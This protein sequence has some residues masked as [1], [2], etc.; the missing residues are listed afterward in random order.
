M[1]TRPRIS[2]VVLAGGRSRRFG[3]DKLSEVVDGRP[4]LAHAVV[5]V[6]AVADEVIVVAGVGELAVSLEGARVVHDP[7]PFEGPLAGLAVGLRACESPL[8]IVIGGDMPSLQSAVGQALLDRLLSGPVDAAVL[9]QEGGRRP[10]PLAVRREPALA[11][12]ERLLEHGERSLRALAA[13]LG[14]V[15]V[16]AAQWRALDPEGRSVRDVDSPDDLG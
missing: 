3:R 1:T 5:S 6:R 13:A 14:A 11:A 15:K 2:A 7:L 4:L 12:A 10:L 9:E 8:A 16:P